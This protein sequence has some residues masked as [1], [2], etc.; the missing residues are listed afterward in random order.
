[1]SKKERPSESPTAK[2]EKIG[3]DDEEDDLA[4]SSILTSQ[5]ILLRGLVR[6]VRGADGI[7]LQQA[8]VL[9]ILSEDGATSMNGLSEQLLV[10]PPNVTGIVD[11]LEEKGLVMRVES[12]VD[13]RRTEIQLTAKGETVHRKLRQ[14][15]RET[16]GRSLD[17]A[18]DER[19]RRMLATMLRKV[20]DQWEAASGKRADEQK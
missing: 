3:V 13:R 15:Y 5:R 12:K 14:S 16:L 11:R 19:E 2:A 8:A 17:L 10:T 6:T 7:T 20:A 1:M 9:R 18:L 4:L